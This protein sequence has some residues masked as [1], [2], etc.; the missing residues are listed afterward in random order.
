MEKSSASSY[1]KDPLELFSTLLQRKSFAIF[2]LDSTPQMYVAQFLPEI[3][4]FI[5][6][7][8]SLGLDSDVLFLVTPFVDFLTVFDI[9]HHL[10]V[11]TA[12]LL[13]LHTSFLRLA[14][15]YLSC[16]S[17]SL[18]TGILAQQV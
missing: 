4:R 7:K 3:R 17:S 1:W 6:V 5:L 8:C 15:T 18:P 10:P 13:F 14:G 2:L 16:C 11:N 9:L 12:S